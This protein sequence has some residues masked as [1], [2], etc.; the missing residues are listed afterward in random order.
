MIPPFGIW[1]SIKNIKHMKQLKNLA[2]LFLLSGMMLTVITCKKDEAV[3]EGTDLY[4]KWDRGCLW[5]N[6]YTCI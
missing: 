2:F 6:P 5:Q 4:G 1:Y 3:I